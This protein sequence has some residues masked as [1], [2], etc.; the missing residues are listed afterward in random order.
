MNWKQEYKQIRKFKAG[1][2][3]YEIEKVAIGLVLQKAMI[4][5]AVC[6]YYVL[7]DRL[8]ERLKKEGLKVEKLT[9]TYQ[10]SGWDK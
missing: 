2:D 10:V 1:H 4:E 8:A 3:L 6:C 5:G 9:Y 7:S